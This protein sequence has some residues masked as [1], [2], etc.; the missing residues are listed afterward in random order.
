MNDYD[1]SEHVKE[2]YARFGLA[3]YWAQVLE[4]GLVNALVILDLIPSRRHLVGSRDKWEITVDAFM[5]QHFEETMGRLMKNLRAV[6][7]VPS[8][9]EDLLRDALKR[10]N[11]L[12]HG[13]FRDRATEFLNPAGRD[14]MLR[15]VDDCRACFKTADD[16]LDEV[17]NP[18]RKK[19][20]ITDEM[21]ERERQ[22]LLMGH[23]PSG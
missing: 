20:G 7:A 13:F 21:L 12:A 11:W 16:R 9:L 17:V 15:E 1:E 5:D 3:I 2:V 8:G 14:Q 22:L 18:L 19:A 6:S 4:Y 10:R 23:K